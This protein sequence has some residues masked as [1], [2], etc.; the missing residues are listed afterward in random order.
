VE[1]TFTQLLPIK[2]VK[3]NI[4]KNFNIKQ[5]KRYCSRMTVYKREKRTTIKTVTTINNNTL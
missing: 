1:K 5:H 4:T 2:Q 3:K